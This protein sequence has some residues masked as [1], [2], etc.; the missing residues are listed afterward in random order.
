MSV[1]SPTPHVG[2]NNRRQLSPTKKMA[3]PTIEHPSQRMIDNYRTSL[4]VQ[5]NSADGQFDSKSSNFSDYIPDIPENVNVV[6]GED[7]DKVR[8]PIF[9]RRAETRASSCS[10]SR[11]SQTPQTS[12]LIIDELE[13]T[14][15]EKV[16]SQFHNVRTKFRHAAHND[17]NGKIDRQALQ[18]F[19]S[20]IFGTQKQVAP[21]QI[22]KLLERLNLKRFNK[23]S[24]DD[25]ILS[26]STGQDLPN[27]VTRQMSGKSEK[28]SKKTATQMFLIL[29]EKIQTK[30]KDVINLCPSIAGGPSSRLF[31][32]YLRDAINDMGYRITDAEFDKLWDR[33]E[34]NEQNAVTSERF[35]KAFCNDVTEKKEEEDEEEDEI[36]NTNRQYFMAKCHSPRMRNVQSSRSDRDLITPVFHSTRG[37]LDENQ[38]Q[39]WLNYKFPHGFS[40]LERALESLDP[41]QSGTLPR[42]RFLEQLKRFGLNLETPLLEFFLKRLNVDL[43]LTNDGIPY[44]EV[45]NAFKQSTDP[46]KKRINADNPVYIEDD[47]QTALE[48]KI[49]QALT[50]NSERIQDLLKRA[51]PT[52]SELVS[53]NTIRAIIEDLIDYTLKPDEY[54]QLLKNIPMDQDGKVRYNDYLKQVADRASHYPEEKQLHKPKIP[55][56]DFMVP[57]STRD[58]NNTKHLIPKHWEKLS[59]H[60]NNVQEKKRPINELSEILKTLVRDRYKDVEDAF[61]HIDRGSYG[62]LTQDLLYDLLKRLSIEPEI[63]RSEIDLIWERCLLK[64]DGTL[65]FYQFLRQFG[66]SKHSAHYPNARQR[67]PRKGDSDLV[68]TSNKLYGESIIV[69]GNVRNMVRTNG[70]KLRRMFAELDPYRTGY[71]QPEEFD[72][73][74]LELCPELNQ[75]DLYLIKSKLQTFDDPRMNYVSFLKYYTPNTKSINHTD[76]STKNSLSINNENPYRMASDQLVFTQICIKL[77]RK[78]SDLYSQLRRT[79]K[80]QDKLNC[81]SIPIKIF[82]N[83]LHQYGCCLNDEEFFILTSHIDT[84]L[85]GTINYNYFLQQYIKNV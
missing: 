68:L 51:D 71:V 78:L 60:Y 50:K 41:K 40:E 7:R 81:G 52:H 38:V 72:E 77:R 53:I 63:T 15:R 39:K 61:R 36:S 30:D 62:E 34:T 75:E 56:Y 22:D 80:Q 59:N 54:H 83:I 69:H 29:K 65:D 82:K 8:L 1:L 66:Y 10:S 23:I 45:I 4:D 67:P 19:I 11:K 46:T 85:D 47:R 57:T 49:D 24:F 70:D 25:F 84:Q 5:G 33:F 18:H 14:L 43:A 3:L 27:W 64:R 2:Y 74:L 28:S 42:E 37:R 20:T 32:V 44:Q 17:P 21:I 16:R 12:R 6:Y 13:V 31:K 73:I 79:F 55:R 76:Y 48:R 26:V 35:L 9:G 58:K